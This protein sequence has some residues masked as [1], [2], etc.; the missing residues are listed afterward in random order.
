MKLRSAL[1]T[2]EHPSGWGPQRAL[3]TM[4]GFWA[5]PHATWPF[6]FGQEPL[7]VWVKGR[8]ALQVILF[9]PGLFHVS[10]GEQTELPGSSVLFKV[11]LKSD[12]PPW[13][14]RAGGLGPSLRWPSLVHLHLGG[15][16][17]M[18]PSL[19]PLVATPQALVAPQMLV[20]MAKWVT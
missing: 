5:A 7:Q 14:P 18:A 16:I 8:Q 19:G 9:C 12:M 1:Q 6:C 15:S 4:W 10:S 3:T 11:I 13:L 20:A 2:P 17:L